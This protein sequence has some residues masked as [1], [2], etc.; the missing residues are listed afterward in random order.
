LTFTTLAGDAGH[1]SAD[2]TGGNAR[3]YNPSSVAA[4]SAGN[5]Y[6]ADTQN[7]T[8]RKVTP[9]GVV[10]TLAGLAGSYG[11]TDGMG[12]AARFNHPWG[13]AV[14]IAGN[15]YVADSGNHT[16]RKMTLAGQVTTIG[17]APGVAS[18]EDGVGSSAR[19]SDPTGIAVD[20]AGNLYVADSKN[21]R[22]S[23]GTLLLA[24]DIDGD[25]HVDVA[26]LLMLVNSWGKAA[27]QTGF[28]A[29]CDLDGDGRV[30]ILDLLAV[31]NH[32]G[33]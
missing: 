25:G 24:G 29:R 5:L 20:G 33:M 22:I 27:G 2:G 26:D 9:S 31:V 32:W 13:V 18:G 15:V 11:S 4:D 30:G 17:G 6:V 16:V 12:S 19:F 23:K 1:G 10:T 8:I 21:N 28:D 3:F 14:D 7:H